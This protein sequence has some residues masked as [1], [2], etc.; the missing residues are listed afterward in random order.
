MKNRAKKEIRETS[1]FIIATGNIK[2]HGVTL[3]KQVKDL[4]DKNFK[5]LKKEC[6]E[7]ARK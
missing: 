7:D 1:F 4:Y 2:Y 6:E 3:A 5:P